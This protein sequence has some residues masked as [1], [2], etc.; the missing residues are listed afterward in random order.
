MIKI[1][2]QYS[3]FKAS[4]SCSKVLNVKSI[5]N[6]VKD[7]TVSAKLLKNPE[8]WQNFQY[9]TLYSVYIHLEMIRV[10]WA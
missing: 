8:W 3:E 2:I 7:F 10:F 4:T 9:A 6:A 5:C 1:Y